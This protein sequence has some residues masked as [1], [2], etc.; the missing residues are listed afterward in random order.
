MVSAESGMIARPANQGIAAAICRVLPDVLHSGAA[1][2]GPTTPIGRS[3]LFV[4][5]LFLKLQPICA[6]LPCIYR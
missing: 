4:P 2:T 3:R 6:C 1:R 5:S